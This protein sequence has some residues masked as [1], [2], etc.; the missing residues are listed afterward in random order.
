MTTKLFSC[1]SY[2][3]EFTAC[4]T[5]VNK[6]PK[7]YVLE[8]D[9]TL[10]YPES[11][12]QNCDTGTIY[13]SD[14]RQW[15]VVEVFYE[16]SAIKHLI[17]GENPP[18]KGEPITGRIHWVR[19]YTHMQRHSAQHLL[20][21]AF[22]RVDPAFRT[23]SVAMSSS[24]CTIDFEGFPDDDDIA[25]AEALCN[26]ICREGIPITV[27]EVDESEIGN[28]NV[29]RPPKVSGIIRL[30]KA[31]DYETAACGGTHLEN[32][33]EALPVKILR[34]EKI[35]GDLTRI[36]FIAGSEAFEDYIQKHE[37][38]RALSE[39]FSSKVHAIP[40]HV[41]NLE[42]SLSTA[43]QEIQF[44]SAMVARQLFD[45]ATM[46]QDPLIIIEAPAVDVLKKLMAIA[47]ETPDTVFAGFLT[48][49]SKLE[50]SL[51]STCPEKSMGDVVKKLQLTIAVKGGGRKEMARFAAQVADKDLIKQ[52]L[53]QILSN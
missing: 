19:R 6:T 11:G 47:G 52:T 30:V 36:H 51:I 38:T 4:V 49:E 13:T 10:F 16:G 26:E 42:S 15:S 17:Y 53:K 14:A 22:V 45:E 41:A 31:G 44:L 28:W 37:I 24:V 48:T 29:R 34:S 33:A 25:R 23:V 50:V 39:G 27:H 12:G 35:R 32:T 7:G 5:E 21:Q 18:S 43:K 20:S 2:E 40:M 8:F 1:N 46:K 9:R 3:T